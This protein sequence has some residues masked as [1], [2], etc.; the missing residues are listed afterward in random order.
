MWVW[1]GNPSGKGGY[2][3]LAEYWATGWKAGN[4][5]PHSAVQSLTNQ[6]GSQHPSHLKLSGHTG[7]VE[8]L[9]L[10]RTKQPPCLDIYSTG[11]QFSSNFVDHKFGYR[12]L[13]QESGRTCVLS[14]FV[15]LAHDLLAGHVLATC[16]K[17]W[18]KC[19]S[20]LYNKVWHCFIPCWTKAGLVPGICNWRPAPSQAWVQTSSVILSRH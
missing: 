2:Q 10:K 3:S 7:I 4:C 8:L 16:K 12:H 14:L 6:M 20:K 18:S 19:L 1:A 13:K 9:S 5:S 11:Q 15:D 17:L